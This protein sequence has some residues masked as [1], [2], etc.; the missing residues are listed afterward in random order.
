MK[1]WKKK[2]KIIVL[3]IFLILL[4]LFAALCWKKRRGIYNTY[5]KLTGQEIPY[6]V[7]EKRK[8]A[9]GYYEQKLNV[10]MNLEDTIPIAENDDSAAAVETTIPQEE[11]L[12]AA[13]Y[14]IDRQLQ[15]E[16]ENGYSWEEPMVIQN[17]YQSAPLTAVV[18]FD[19]P[20]ECAVRFTVKGKT[21]AADISGEIEASVSH[22]VP[23]IGL[24]PDMDNTVVLELLDENGKVTASQELTIT[25]E[26]LPEKLTDAVKPVKVSGESAFELTMVYG[27]QTTYPF[28]YDC[29]GDIRWYLSG[30]KTTGLY[31]LSNC[32]M[33]VADK[34]GYVPSQEK[35][36]PTNLYELDYLGRAYT[37][38]YVAAGN[39][40]EVIEKEPGGNLLVLTSSLEGH[41]EDK[42]QEIDRQTGEVV[43]ELIMGDIIDSEYEDR[44]DWTHLN[45]V[46][47]QPET[48]TVVI[49]PRNLESVIKINWT[50]KEIQ[51]ILCDPRF[52]EGTEYEKYVLQPEGDFVYHFQQHTAYQLDADLDGDSET[53]EIS[54]FDNHAVKLRKKAMEY[55]DGKKESYLLVYSVN[56]KEKTVQQIKKLPVLWSNIT[57]STI[58]DEESNHIFGMSG[59]V[60]VAEDKRHGM[61]YEFDYDT[62]ELINQ[63]SLKDYFYRASEMKL[64]YNDLAAPMELKENYILGELFQP[65]KTNKWLWTKKPEQI[66]E[67]ED[68]TFHLT[69]QVLYVGTYDHQISQILFH[70][71]DNTYVYDTTDIRLHDEDYL[72]YYEHLPVPLQGLAADEYEIYVMYQDGFYDTAQKITIK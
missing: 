67:D 70:G 60:K 53:V 38:Y 36:Q 19:T 72:A 5:M 2:T 25:T 61:T 68:V 7:K 58:Y 29:M 18:I 24:Y 40:H 46:S 42:I 51:W 11:T 28:A 9:Y 33:I 34:A 22:R 37:M 43:N 32:R 56:E 71:K 69:G 47:Y 10:S 16:Q 1:K 50:T 17:P 65:V 23:V 4:V 35:P 54:M 15:A 48:D 59:H 6:S 21:E 49:S 63:F 66:L 62:E 31:M 12:V 30:E 14:E 8:K 52:W 64:D 26:A 44:V 39:H 20:E 45:T 41:I 13:S 27:Q 57:S 3:L 55:Y